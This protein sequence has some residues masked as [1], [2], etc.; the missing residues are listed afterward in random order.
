MGNKIKITARTIKLIAEL[1]SSRTAQ[2]IW[3]ALPVKG[4]ANLWGNEIYFSIPVILTL[5]SGKGLVDMG[6]LCYWPQGN[7]FCIFFGPTPISKGDQIKPASEVSVFGKII[8][9]AAL[10]E[11]VT[12]GTK[13][14]IEQIS[15]EEAQQ[16]AG[17]DDKKQTKALLILDET[18][19]T[20]KNRQIVLKKAPN[21][22]IIVSP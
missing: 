11:K 1:N 3:K 17:Q 7:A 4:F 10:L 22:A 19:S 20:K 15:D 8:G 9:D 5:E 12:S 18:G 13:I 6:D 14:I 21:S 2:A 16:L